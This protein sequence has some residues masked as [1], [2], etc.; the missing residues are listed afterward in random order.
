MPGSLRNQI[1]IPILAVQ[2]LAVC[3]TTLTIATLAARRGERQIIDRLQ[4]VIAT[5][6]D[7]NFPYT[8]SVLARMRGLSGAH[9]ASISSD[10][11]VI[12]SSFDRSPAHLIPA[13]SRVG[14]RSIETLGNA[15]TLKL[16]GVDY[17]PVA[18]RTTTTSNG[19]TLLVL[20][21]ETNWRA[22]RWDALLAPLLLGTGSLVLMA[23]ATTL[24]ARRISARVRRLQLQVASI[25]EGEFRQI[26][27]GRPSDEVRDLALSI[28]RMSLQLSQMKRAIESGERTRL[29]A[30]LAAGLAHQLRN[31]LTGAR[32]S[33]Q[34]HARR[35]PP[36]NGDSSL[37]VALRQLSITEEQVKGLL[38]LGRVEQTAPE[39]C[40][41]IEIF[42]EVE[43]LVGPAC[44]H[45][46]VELH[47]EDQ[48]DP[49]RMLLDKGS[50]RAAILNLTLNAIEAAGPGG[51]VTWSIERS[52][53]HVQIIIRDTGSGPPAHLAESLFD[54]FVTGRPE[55]VGLG[56]AVASDV[57]AAHGGTLSWTR[58]NGQTCFRLSLA[59][60]NG[61]C[62]RVP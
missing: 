11:Q 51:V 4:S 2:V 42:G 21:P 19:V 18:L 7:A 1:L 22:A 3:V 17:R 27:P 52:I 12:A 55:G 43:L 36:S 33:V 16:D 25:A 13:L 8:A 45:A 5:L 61:A 58:E 56:L 57:A 40:D 20:Y 35:H 53:D 14:S 62:E 28:N 24:I 29:L 50:F 47:R 10:G 6:T 41:L 39:W 32:M 23:M 59:H 48:L 54:P 49:A 34:L 30:Q 46:K 37:D 38:S 31:A 44:Q 9:F 15:T 26:E 60:T